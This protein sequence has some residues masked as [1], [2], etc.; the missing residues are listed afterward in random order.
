VHAHQLTFSRDFSNGYL[1]A[2]VVAWYYPQD[3]Q[4]HSYSNGTSIQTKLG[5]WQ[6][7]ERVSIL[8]FEKKNYDNIMSVQH[9]FCHNY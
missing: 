2:E 1:V 7:L 3:I 8:I 9:D 4:M 6:Q 5:N